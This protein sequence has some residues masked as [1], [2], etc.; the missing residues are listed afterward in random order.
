MEVDVVWNPESKTYDR[1][2]IGNWRKLYCITCEVWPV[3]AKKN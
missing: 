1:V 2:P 3:L